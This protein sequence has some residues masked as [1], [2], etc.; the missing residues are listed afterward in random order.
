MSAS[1]GI[2]D[3]AGARGVDPILGSPDLTID[4]L[5]PAGTTLVFEPYVSLVCGDCNGDGNVA[6]TDALLAAQHDVGLTT[7]TGDAYAACNVQ[8]V[9]GGEGTLGASVSILDALEVARF[10]AGMVSNL[11]CM[12]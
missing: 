2:E 9:P 4:E 10:A 6:I 1:C 11:A 12:P 8:G 7:I 3:L 5:P